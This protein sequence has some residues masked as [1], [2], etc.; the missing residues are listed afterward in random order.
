VPPFERDPVS[1]L[2]DGA[3]RALLRRAIDARG[4]W[5]GTRIADPSERQRAMLRRMGINVNARDNPSA[6][7]GLSRGGNG[8]NA[9]TRWARGFVRAVF[10]HNDRRHGGRGRS[11]D[12]EVGRYLPAGATVPAGYA[13]RLR[14]VPGGAAA[15]RAARRLPDAARIYTDEGGPGKRWSDPDLRD[16]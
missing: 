13:V 2:W 16:W 1:V 11:L 8:I 12:L 7:A 5:Q 6:Q 3:A 15:A 10:Y 14:T 9:H 4:E